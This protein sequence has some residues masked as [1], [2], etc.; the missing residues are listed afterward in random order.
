GLRERSFWACRAVTAVTLDGL[1]TGGLSPGAGLL[2]FGGF[3]QV[4]RGGLLGL[5]EG[6]DGVGHDLDGH[7]WRDLDLGD[8][9][10][11]LDELADEARVRHHLVAP[12]EARARRR[13]LLLL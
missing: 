9:V 11:G 12:F 5:H 7:A 10:V 4:L 1:S 3:L 13:F 8:A 2:L 6:R